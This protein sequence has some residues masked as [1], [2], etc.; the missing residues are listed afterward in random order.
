MIGRGRPIVAAGLIE[1]RK[2]FFPP[3]PPTSKQSIACLSILVRI[4]FFSWRVTVLDGGEDLE[5]FTII[6]NISES[7]AC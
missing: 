2:D 5:L 4:F 6:N 7:Y 1:W 3:T